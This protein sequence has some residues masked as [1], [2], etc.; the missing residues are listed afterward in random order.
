[1]SVTFQNPGLIDPRAITTFGV[2]VKETDNPI[3]HFGTGLKYA[4]GILLRHNQQVRIF[5]G[6]DELHVSSKPVTIR[7][8]SFSLVT[9]AGQE[10]GFTTEI[11]KDW[12][13]WAA[14]RELHCNAKDEAGV[15]IYGAAAPQA[16]HTTIIVSGAEF[17]EVYA[18]RDEIF[19]SSTPFIDTPRFAIHSIPSRF[20]F[21][22]GIRVGER[23]L[24]A[25]Y[26]YDC[27]QAIDLTE[28]RTLRWPWAFDNRLT[29]AIQQDVTDTMFLFRVLTAGPEWA[30]GLFDYDQGCEPSSAFIDT[31]RSI[32]KTKLVPN[33]S[34]YA[35]YRHYIG[36]N[37]PRKPF[38]ISAKHQRE[39][40]AARAL[41]SRHGFDTTTCN[42]IVV[43]SLGADRL[44]LA[45]RDTNTIVLAAD[46][47]RQGGRLLTST[48]FEEYLHLTHG[49][50][51]CTR[52]MQNFLFNLSL[53]MMERLDDNTRP[54]S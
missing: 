16:G 51:D 30:E 12:P 45:E 1:M 37:E 39:I 17:D 29:R 54:G 27:K 20:Y 21:N 14:F 6:L 26:T 44:A 10:L 52:S 36:K 33:K 38:P 13:L 28:D 40:D 19:L 31:M 32:C 18:K 22:K 48:I 43:E 24:R 5:V 53:D 47:I 2:N 3:G 7:G 35:V 42:L 41:L 11:G 23:A 46:T 9:L 50:D 34:A 49:L 4:L 8:K 15:T 25:L